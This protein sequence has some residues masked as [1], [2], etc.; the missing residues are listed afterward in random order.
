M[1]LRSFIV[2]AAVLIA[3]CAPDR[4]LD[5]DLTARSEFGVLRL[6]DNDF[7]IV[8]YP[9]ERALISS[10]QLRVSGWSGT[11]T[12]AEIVFAEPI[13]SNTL[14]V[15]VDSSAG[16]NVLLPADFEAFANPSYLVTPG[17]GEHYSISATRDDGSVVTGGSR[18]SS[19]FAFPVGS[20]GLPSGNYDP[21]K[22]RCPDG[23]QAWTFTS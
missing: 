11:E 21:E 20:I 13:E 10:V 5:E 7:A 14:L 3:S 12:V 1:L 15:R 19:R 16:W 17:S 23:T 6:S 18:L 8:L 4:K 9:C 22:S 2:V